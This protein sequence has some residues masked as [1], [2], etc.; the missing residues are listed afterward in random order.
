MSEPVNVWTSYVRMLRRLAWVDRVQHVDMDTLTQALSD[1][2]PR[3]AAS[4][5]EEIERRGLLDLLR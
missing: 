1:D 4:A 3:I 2:D 5:A